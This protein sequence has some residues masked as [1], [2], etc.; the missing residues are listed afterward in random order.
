MV[1]VRAFGGMGKTSLVATW[2]AELAMKNW[3]GAERVFDWTFY[4]QGTSDQRAASA[5]AFIAAALTAFGDPDPTVGSAWDRGARLAHLVGRIRCLL[6]LD[7]L[8]PLQY[9]PGAMEG[10]LKDAAIEAL[11]KGLAAHNAGLC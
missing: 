1:I 8:E 2:M 4:S 10:K 3:R 9:P 5:D 6:V 11:L 7:G